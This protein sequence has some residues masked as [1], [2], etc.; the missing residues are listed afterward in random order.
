MTPR[1]ALKMQHHSSHVQTQDNVVKCNKDAIWMDALMSTQNRLMLGAFALGFLTACSDLNDDHNAD[2]KRYFYKDGTRYTERKS[3]FEA[4]WQE[5]VF[6][7][8]SIWQD[9]TF[10]AS[11]GDLSLSSNIRLTSCMDAQEYVLVTIPPCPAG[12]SETWQLLQPETPLPPFSKVK[13]IFE[14]GQIAV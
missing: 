9:D 4:C 8:M 13:C 7:A 12:A 11:P 3:D 2:R 5:S 14:N 1:L 10:V 6:Y